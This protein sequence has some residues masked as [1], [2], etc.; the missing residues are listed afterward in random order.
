[1]LCAHFRWSRSSD[2]VKQPDVRLIYAVTHFH[3]LILFSQLLLHDITTTVV[4]AT[5]CLVLNRP[6]D[7]YIC[8]SVM[9][10]FSDSSTK[11]YQYSQEDEKEIDAWHLTCSS[12]VIGCTGIQKSNIN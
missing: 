12:A 10:I 9:C 3:I 2:L 7:V 8:C 5:W 11:G 1:M 6:A 4:L